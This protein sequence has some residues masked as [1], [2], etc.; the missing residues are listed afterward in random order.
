VTCTI[1]SGERSEELQAQQ[2]G[3]G[4]GIHMAMPSMSLSET[5]CDIGE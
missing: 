5:H 1:R 4:N 2:A 3:V